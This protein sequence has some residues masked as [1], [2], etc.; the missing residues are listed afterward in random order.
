MGRGERVGGGGEHVQGRDQGAG[1][2]ENESTA[3]EALAGEVPEHL[4]GVGAQRKAL[5]P[6]VRERT[7]PSMQAGG[8]PRAVSTSRRVWLASQPLGTGTR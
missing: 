1:G 4:E 8:V 6:G 7:A 5:A 2:W 3:R